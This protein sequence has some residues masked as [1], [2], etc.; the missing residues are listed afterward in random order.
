MI[1]DEFIMIFI[2]LILLNKDT[3]VVIITRQREGLNRSVRPRRNSFHSQS[4]DGTASVDPLSS[5]VRN[6]CR[7][8][9]T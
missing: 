2:N 3:K 4:C 9:D 1:N 8:G 7:R 5:D 6:L